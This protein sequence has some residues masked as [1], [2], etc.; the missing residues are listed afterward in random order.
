MDNRELAKAYIQSLS[1]YQRDRVIAQLQASMHR[2]YTLIKNG[3]ADEKT[4]DDFAHD[5]ILWNALRESQ[6]TI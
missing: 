4:C 5:V 1:A 3:R 2:G 6:L